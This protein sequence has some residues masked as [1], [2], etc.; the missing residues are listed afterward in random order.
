MIYR[1]KK[2]VIIDIKKH[3]Q[4]ISLVKWITTLLRQIVP[5]DLFKLKV[6]IYLV[7]LDLTKQAVQFAKI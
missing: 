1:V 3:Y 4:R 6:N 5:S 7:L 2:V